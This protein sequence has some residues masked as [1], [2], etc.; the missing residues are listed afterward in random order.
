MPKNV[1]RVM[2]LDFESSSLSPDSWPIEVGLSW[3]AHDQVCTWSSLICPAPSWDPDDW[4]SVSSGIHNIPY[5]AIIAA[6]AATQVAHALYDRISGRQLV[7][8]NPAFEMRW[9][10]KLMK[11]IGVPTPLVHDFD[12]LVHEVFR[13]H[14]VVLD[15]LYEKMEKI[16]HPHR[17]GDDSRRLA[18]A[19]LH[20]T[21][22]T[23]QPHQAR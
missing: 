22:L 2:T 13:D 8:D 19:L 3:I 6:P 21:G 17:A 12:N 7:S 4:S 14:S 15:H 16:P 1:D 18:R 20:G 11:L 23:G 9:A 10:R 5:S